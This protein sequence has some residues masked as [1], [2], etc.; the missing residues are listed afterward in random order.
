MGEE[1]GT[2]GEETHAFRFRAVQG[3]AV[4][5]AGGYHPSQFE[6]RKSGHGLGTRNSVW[7]YG[8]RTIKG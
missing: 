5:E 1:A 2:E 4:E 6:M 8:I 3:H 7:E